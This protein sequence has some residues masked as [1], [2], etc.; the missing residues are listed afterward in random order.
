M[1]IKANNIAKLGLFLGPL[2]ALLIGTLWHPDN[3]GSAGVYTA[4]LVALM[5]IW[6]MTEA[7]PIAVTAL[8]PLALFGPL[9]V[10]TSK[11]AAAAYAHPIIFLFLGGFIVALAIE[12]TNLHKRI[13]LSILSV[14]NQSAAS[15]VGAFMVVAMFLSMWMTNTATTIMLLPIAMSVVAMLRDSLDQQSSQDIKY[16]AIALLLGIAYSAS[17]GGM[18]T[19]VGTAPNAFL[20]AYVS[21]Q[22]NRDI[23]FLDWMLVGVPTALLLLPIIWVVVTKVAFK[24]TMQLNDDAKQVITQARNALGAMSTGEKRTALIFALLVTGWMTRPLIQAAGFLPSLNDTAFAITAA[25]AVCIVKRGPNQ[26]P[27]VSWSDTHRVPWGV[28]LLLGGGLSMAGAITSSGLAAYWGELLSALDTVQFSV[29]IVAMIAAMIFITE[30][31][32]NTASTAT[33]VPIA[34]GIAIALG[35]QAEPL[36][37]PLTLAASCAFMLPVATPPNA[38]VFGSGEI[39]TQH[40]MR[41]GIWLNLMSVLVLA[42]IALWLVPRVFG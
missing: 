30:V 14:A 40:M 6:W 29:L 35:Q 9:Q 5:A 22:L 27:L 3:L 13:A 23:G 28:L 34:A 21:E 1:T 11:A 7:V 38:I 33:F 17:V 20:A 39:T 24:V 12:N 10:T 41:A 25:I 32:S 8:I 31:S 42:G 18:A 16:F 26:A 4:A 36:I 2:V 19:L 15:V 37:V